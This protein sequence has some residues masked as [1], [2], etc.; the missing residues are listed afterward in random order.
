[1][2][3]RLLEEAHVVAAGSESATTQAIRGE[4]HIAEADQQHPPIK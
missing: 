1:M 4:A 3:E 2:F